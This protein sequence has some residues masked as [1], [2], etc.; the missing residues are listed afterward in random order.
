MNFLENELQHVLIIPD[1]NRR[2]AKENNITHEEVYR[3]AAEEITPLIIRHFLVEKRAKELTFFMISRDNLLKRDIEN[4]IFPIL[5]AQRKMYEKFLADQ[6]FA[7]VGIRFRFVGDEQLLPEDY[8][9]VSRKLEESSRG[10]EG[11]RCNF[12]AAY[13]AE[14]ELLKAFNNGILKKEAIL[15]HNLTP[16]LYLDS[17]ID[18]VIRS[19]F[20]HRIS[21]APLIQMAYAEIYFAD[22]FYPEFT[23]EKL[24]SV[25]DDYVK[26]ERRFGK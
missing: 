1:G 26:R 17:K 9:S 10:R 14:W 6:T 25:Y 4:D 21:A 22:F 13:D 15:D 19:G 2:W 5:E 11:P 3:I 7:K 24:E 20:E 16:Y 12:L 23:K 8:I 18:L